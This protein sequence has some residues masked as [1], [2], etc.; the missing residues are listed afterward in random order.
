MCSKQM[1]IS[2]PIQ[3]PAD[4]EENACAVSGIS[5]KKSAEGFVLAGRADDIQEQEGGD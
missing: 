5:R 2:K 1:E 3:N 4:Q